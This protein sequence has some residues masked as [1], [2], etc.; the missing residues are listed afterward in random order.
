MPDVDVAAR[1]LTDAGFA[2]SAPHQFEDIGYM[3]HLRDPEGFQIE[4]LQHT[5]LGQPKTSEGDKAWALA[6]GTALGQV[7]LRTSDIERDLALY[8]DTHAMRLLSIQPVRAY[9]FDLYFLTHSDD[10][11]PNEDLKSVENRPWLWQRLYCTLELQHIL[12]ANETTEPKAGEVGYQG[13]IF[14]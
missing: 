4:L 11:P 9:G 8:R 10:T 6:G 7:T 13:L 12:G 14:E 2:A 5:F 1:M 3:S